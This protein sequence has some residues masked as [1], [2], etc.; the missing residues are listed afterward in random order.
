MISPTC[1]SA[2]DRATQ[3][4]AP[5]SARRSAQCRDSAT[6]R[7]CPPPEQRRDVIV[8]RAAARSG[9]AS[10][11]RGGHERRQPRTNALTEQHGQKAVTAPA[12]QIAMSKIDRIMCERRCRPASPGA[13]LA[14]RTPAAAPDSCEFTQRIDQRD[15]PAWSRRLRRAPYMNLRWSPCRR[16]GIRNSSAHVTASACSSMPTISASDAADQPADAS[17][18]L[19]REDARD[20]SRRRTP[21]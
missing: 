21:A 2:I 20:A 16:P 1:T 12:I 15:T 14:P 13:P 19:P 6:P 11:Q 18:A 5:V 7:R 3:H 17:A 4:E 10:E 8:D 9:T